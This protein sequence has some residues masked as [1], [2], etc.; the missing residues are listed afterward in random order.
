MSRDE[1][2][3]D[4]QISHTFG[5]GLVRSEVDEEGAVVW[6]TPDAPHG[7]LVCALWRNKQGPCAFAVVTVV[8]RSGDA[9]W[10][11]EADA[12]QPLNPSTPRR[13]LHQPG[14]RLGGRSAPA[15]AAVEPP[16]QDGRVTAF[17]SLGK[18]SRVQDKGHY[19]ALVMIIAGAM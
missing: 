8:D 13:S 3:T 17:H 5:P 12:A 18:P 10:G 7:E 4:V 6:V 1:V 2:L 15:V 19:P 14:R 11:C 16:G 9:V